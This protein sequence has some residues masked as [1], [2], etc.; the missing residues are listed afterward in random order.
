MDDQA[1][2]LA[3]AGRAEAAAAQALV[4]QHGVGAAVG[5]V[6]DGLVDVLD[7]FDGSDG[8]A[9]IHRNNDGAAGFTIEDTLETNLLA[10]IHDAHPLC[11]CTGMRA[12]RSAAKRKAADGCT[13]GPE[14]LVLLYDNVPNTLVP[15]VRPK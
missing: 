7:A 6:G 2:V 15:Q 4:H 5:H 1:K 13:R 11:C 14:C 10:E 3:F 12:L 8:H 9:V